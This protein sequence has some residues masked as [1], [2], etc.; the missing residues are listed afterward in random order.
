MA[1]LGIDEVGRG[2]LAG[3]LV[4]A[5]VI[6]PDEIVESQPD[7][8]GD[9]KDSKKLSAKKREKLAE[10]I[11]T[12]A[13]AGVGYV[14]AGEID[15]LGM[16][17]VLRLGARRAVESVRL[18][19]KEMGVGFS[20]III[21]GTMNFL[22]G[23]SL[24]KYVTTVVKGDDLVKEISAASIVAKQARD[25]YMVQAA[26]EYPEYGFQ[27]HVGYGTVRHREAI[28]NFGLCPE[29]RR[30]V[31]LV[32]EIAVRDGEDVGS[33]YD[34][35]V[36]KNT[37]MI[38][39]RAE[40]KVVEYLER[41]EHQVIARNFKTKICEIDIISVRGEK[42]YFT[43]VKYRKNDNYG[44]GVAAIDKKKLE[45]MKVGVEM[46]LKYKKGIEQYNP[47][48]AVADVTG[49]DFFVKDWFEIC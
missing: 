41:L 1:I 4:L 37:T 40:E 45:K 2:P 23:T 19:A 18:A 24:E 10:I 46:F 22:A 31:K 33:V 34:G 16:T 48:L 3:P 6:L 27:Q 42:I 49:A 17:E 8:Y 44:G 15:R 13:V 43:E 9:L 11:N 47:M 28:S 32:R 35:G 5:A 12:E 39:N 14:M 29:H 7:W 26:E 20:E 36:S 21:D 38:G 30:L 25:Y